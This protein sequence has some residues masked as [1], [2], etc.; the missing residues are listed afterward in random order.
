M[1]LLPRRGR[2]E[3]GAPSLTPTPAHVGLPPSPPRFHFV[4][5]CSRTSALDT[6]DPL[7]TPSA[8]RRVQRV[9]NVVLH[10][11]RAP[12]LSESKRSQLRRD[13]SGVAC[14]TCGLRAAADGCGSTIRARLLLDFP[15]ALWLSWSSHPRSDPLSISPCEGERWNGFPPCG[16]ARMRELV[17]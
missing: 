17:I 9:P 7:A 11:F 5:D 10:R 15:V 2:I 12:N 8:L 13:Q 14:E 6:L 1:Y 16:K 3:E 4:P